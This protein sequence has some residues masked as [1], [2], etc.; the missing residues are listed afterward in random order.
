MPHEV[1]IKLYVLNKVTNRMI[2]KILQCLVLNYTTPKENAF[3]V[4]ISINLTLS[5]LQKKAM[6]VF[7]GVD[8]Q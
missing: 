1:C 6:S 7:L 5:G 4:C 2:N 8:F 3:C